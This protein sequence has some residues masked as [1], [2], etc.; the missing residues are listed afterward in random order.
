MSSNL[1][2]V[3]SASQYTLILLRS[4]LNDV[5]LPKKQKPKTHQRIKM[6]T[7]HYFLCANPQWQRP[8]ASRLTAMQHFTPLL[9]TAALLSASH[10]KQSFFVFFSP[11]NTAILYTSAAK[12]TGVPLPVCVEA[13]LHKRHVT[14]YIVFDFKSVNHLLMKRF[15]EV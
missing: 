6:S 3:T 10:G 11:G 1:Q 14:K 8:K 9:A 7:T 15:A 13:A 4:K 2:R 5:D 12:W